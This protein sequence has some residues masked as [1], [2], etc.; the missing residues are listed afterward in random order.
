MANGSSSSGATKG[1]PSGGLGNSAGG[2]IRVPKN[3]GNIPAKKNPF[4]PFKTYQ[5]EFAQAKD[6]PALKKVLED[7]GVAISDKFEKYIATGQYPIEHAKA[8]IKGSLLTISHYGDGERL[9]GFGAYQVMTN[10][11]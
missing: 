1:G 2:G 8:F 4:K 6:A 11:L 10:R 7:N 9:I 3:V 5:K